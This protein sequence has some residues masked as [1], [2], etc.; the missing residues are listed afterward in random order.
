MSEPITAEIVRELQDH[1]D[2]DATMHKKI[3]ENFT[4]FNLALYGN[5][6]L[7]IKGMIAKV[8]EI[9]DIF[10]AGGSVKRVAV[11]IFGTFMAIIGA[12]YTIIKLIKEAKS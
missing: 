8:D 10:T 7:K 12:V 6:D 3:D 5:E 1:K 9:Y 4:K 11:W 2:E